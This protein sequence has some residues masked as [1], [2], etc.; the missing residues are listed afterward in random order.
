LISQD[1]SMRSPLHVSRGCV[2]VSFQVQASEAVV[3]QFRTELLHFVRDNEAD[4]VVVDMS[5]VR[6]LDATDF[7]SLRATLDM[8]RLLG[9]N[10]V[11]TG[12]RP[13]V[14]AAIV[15]LGLDFR[16]PTALDLDHGFDIVREL[17]GRGLAQ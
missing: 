12:L 11:I 14:V 9:V 13:G 4:S 17:R 8:T 1:T 6:L 3:R 2:Q 15:E 16:D 5:G 10:I 7:A